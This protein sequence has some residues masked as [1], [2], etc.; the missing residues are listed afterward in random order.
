MMTDDTRHRIFQK[1]LKATKGVYLEFD[2][3]PFIIL[4]H[5]LL[6]CQN[7]PDH[8]RALKE[9]KSINSKVK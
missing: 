9:K 7:G 5:K 3:I 6:E 1:G 8:N 2:G 4:E